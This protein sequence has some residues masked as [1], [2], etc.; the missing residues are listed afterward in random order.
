MKLTNQ[1]A[2]HPQGKALYELARTFFAGCT[3]VVA[4]FK[5]VPAAKEDEATPEQLVES[6]TRAWLQLTNQQ[7]NHVMAI[8]RATEPEKRTAEQRVMIRAY[9]H[10]RE[11]VKFKLALMRCM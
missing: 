3:E 9:Q 1:N 8:A 2:K 6:I 5:V 4:N 7:I 11:N 10:I